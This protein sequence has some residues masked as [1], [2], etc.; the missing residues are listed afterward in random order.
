MS[1]RIAMGLLGA[2]L[3]YAIG[4]VGGGALVGAAER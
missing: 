4:G 3:S 1:K 2:V